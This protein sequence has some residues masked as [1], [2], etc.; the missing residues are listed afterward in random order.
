MAL[1]AMKKLQLRWVHLIVYAE[2]SE[3]D[4]ALAFLFDKQDS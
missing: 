1:Q 3:R 4:I 2:R